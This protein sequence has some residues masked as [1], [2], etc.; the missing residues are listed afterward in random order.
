MN[1]CAL[2][3][4]ACLAS[5]SSCFAQTPFRVDVKLI[6][7]AASVRDSAGGFIT[8]LGRE[9]FEIIEDG[10]PQKIAFF[11]RSQDVPLNLGLVADFSGSQNPFTKAHHKDVEAFLNGVLGPADRAFLLCF[12]NL[13]RVASEFTASPAELMRGLTAFEKGDRRGF[14]ELGPIEDRTA[15]TAFYDAIYYSATEMLAK[16]ERGRRALILFSDGEDNSSAHHEME[17]LEAAQAHD[18]VLFSIRYTDAKDGRLNSRNKYGASVMERLARDTGGAAFDVR[19]AGL[20]AH[21]QAIGEQLR[22]SYE[23]AYH[24]SNPA[25]DD[26]FHK[27]TIRVKRPGATVRAK[28][29]YYWR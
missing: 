12:G 19:N 8:D 14:P 22:S 28:S 13:L 25:N 17:A 5:A 3:F 1:A 11:A 18:V 4:L 7:V 2:G 6:N 27:I 29:G 9:D 24:S 16:T 20:A 10:V 21:F 23:L 15:G 26:S